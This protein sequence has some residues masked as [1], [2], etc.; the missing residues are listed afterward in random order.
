MS[1]DIGGDHDRKLMWK[2]SSIVSQKALVDEENKGNKVKIISFH[3]GAQVKIL[4]R[5]SRLMLECPP[6]T[7]H[8]EEAVNSIEKDPVEDVVVMD[9]A[10]PHRKP[11][12]HNIKH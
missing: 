11:P 12:I 3:K 6:S 2:K 7:Q 10:Q 9:Y 4:N 5:E 1:E 8:E